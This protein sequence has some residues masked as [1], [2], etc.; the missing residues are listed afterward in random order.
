L[1]SGGREKEHLAEQANSVKGT[2]ET[3]PISALA[4]P[5]P[6]AIGVDA[7]IGAALAAVQNQAQGYVLIVEGGRPR[8]IMSERDVLMKIVARDIKYE[9]NVMEVASRI[10]VTLTDRETIARAI[11]IMIAD[12]A[13]YIPIV[14]N[15]GRATAVLRAVDVMHFLAEAFPREILNLPPRPNQTLPRPEGG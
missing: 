11:K 2:F 5:A 8:A 15:D 13:E 4:L 14:G 3:D 10:G 7:T 12:G 9:T 6:V 1:A